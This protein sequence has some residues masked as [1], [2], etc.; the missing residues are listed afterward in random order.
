MESFERKTVYISESF[1]SKPTKIETTQ[2]LKDLG[3]LLKQIQFLAAISNDF[4]LLPAHCEKS[5]CPSKEYYKTLF[6]GLDTNE[7]VLVDIT[8]EYSDFAKGV[9]FS[10]PKNTL[11]LPVNKKCSYKTLSLGSSGN[12]FMMRTFSEDTFKP[13]LIPPYVKNISVRYDSKK[14][15][16]YFTYVDDYGKSQ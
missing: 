8:A 5:G 15:K 2:I 11:Y 1:V 12:G 13:K 7:V 4:P 3:V 10:E 14:R 9:V 6:K 16:K